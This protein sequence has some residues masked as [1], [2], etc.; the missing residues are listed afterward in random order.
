MRLRN[1][2]LILIAIALIV[3]LVYIIRRRMTANAPPTLPID[4]KSFLPAAWTPI[5]PPVQCDFDGD[6]AG[7]QEWLVLYRYDKSAAN[8]YGLIGGVIFTQRVDRV[9]QDPGIQS[10][11]RP[12][13][14]IPYKLLPD[15]YSG[16]G[17]GYLGEAGAQ[18]RLWAPGTPD[19]NAPCRAQEINV[20]GTNGVYYTRLSVFRWD[21]ASQSYAG[22]HFAG[23]ARITPN[24]VAAGDQ[25]LVTTV[26]TYDRFDDRSLLCQVR[27]YDRPG[28]VA[29]PP[30]SLAFTET[31]SAATIDFC[32]G[33]PNDPAYP[34]A[35][36]LAA[37]RSNNPQSSATDT[38]PTGASFLVQNASLPQELSFLRNAPR[39]PVRVL[40]DRHRG[41]LYQPPSQTPVP[42]PMQG[43]AV[44]NPA[45]DLWWWS[46]EQ[47]RV[48]TT[49]VLPNGNQGDYCWTLRNI[50][51]TRVLADTHWRIESAVPGFCP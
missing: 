3:A 13:F 11:Y 27:R 36:V 24:P 35:V 7:D 33:A 30:A 39:D 18:V 2:I 22:Q 1:V 23:S 48:E 4:L 34:E 50:A 5:T 32:Y 28:S 37:L 14:L 47:A 42:Y 26:T 38:S 31:E 43:T 45:P 25:Q 20:F 41:L 46:A 51:N 29:L 21:E 9:P 10:A 40:V 17:Q 16:K 19:R 49:I 44:P 15:I 8:G 12:A 6:V